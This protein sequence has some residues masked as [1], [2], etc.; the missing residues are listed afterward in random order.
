M[1]SLQEGLATGVRR[2]GQCE[3]R[4]GAAACNRRRPPSPASL[5]APSGLCSFTA[6]SSLF[7]APLLR[8]LVARLRRLEEDALILGR[9]GARPPPQR[10][11][12]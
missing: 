5:P 9:P 3:A 4:A 6:P 10:V 1:G 11:T 7:P 12:D 8:R 2:S